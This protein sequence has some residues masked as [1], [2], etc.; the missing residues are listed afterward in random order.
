MNGGKSYIIGL[1]GASGSGKGE[2]A[3]ILRGL[4]AEVIDA[5]AISHAVVEG[6][7]ALSELSGAFGAWV[8]GENGGFNR[9]AVSERAFSD[10]GFLAHLTAITHKYIIKEINARVAGAT[11]AVAV[12]DAPLPVEK[13]FLDLADAV[14]VVRAP[15]MSRL[16]RVV[17]RDG[18]SEKAAEA[19]FSSQLSDAG[20][21]KLADVIIDNGGGL[22]DLYE[23]VVREYKAIAPA[24]RDEES[25]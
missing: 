18:I 11:A 17:G 25:T 1:T 15:R 9:A 3:K 20:Y 2:T 21:E 5:D 8:I 4:G 13:G 23:A 22:E 24:A 14:W 10:R 6:R 12:I 19:R 16:K 7:E